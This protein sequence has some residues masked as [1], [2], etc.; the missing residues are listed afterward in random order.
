MSSSPYSWQRWA[1]AGVSATLAMG[2]AGAWL[3]LRGA[4]EGDTVAV[5]DH[6]QRFDELLRERARA[7]Q[8]E[9]EAGLLVMG[10]E[11]RA[12]LMRIF[13]RVRE[14]MVPDPVMFYRREGGVNN[15]R[16]FAEHP[17]GGFWVR[18]NSLGM[19]NDA[20]PLVPAANL[21]VLVTGDSHTDGV[22]SNDDSFSGRL[23]DLL[24]LDASGKTVEVLNAGSGGYT[25][26]HYLGVLERYRELEPDVFV[27]AVYGGN[28][29]SGAIKFQRYFRR[30]PP[31]IREPFTMRTFVR[32][33]VHGSG[34]ESQ[35]MVQ[36]AYFLNNPEDVDLAVQTATAVSRRMLEICDEAGCA[37]VFVYLPG[38]LVGQPRRHRDLIASRDAHMGE[39]A[40]ETDPA[41]RIA[42]AWLARCDALAIPTL[43][44]RPLFRASDERLYWETD[45]HLNLAGH[46][47]VA[48]TLLPLVQA[49]S[50]GH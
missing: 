24:R 50:E 35:E 5:I 21:R 16:T 9:S 43:D 39:H 49:A 41:D 47:L 8:V 37:L 33:G 15:W 31:P 27:V 29:F 6:A 42:D 7:G 17:E 3:A 22:C 20:E 25:F 19:R 48:R 36:L 46:A 28:D 1:A 26:Y 14:G 38:P 34:I 44:L 12:E 32:A 40:G 13:Q 4:T 2:A 45:S 11:D 10:E 18:S 23:S 30:R